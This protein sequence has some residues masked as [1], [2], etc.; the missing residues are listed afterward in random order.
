MLFSQ[1]RWLILETA[2]SEAD[3]NGSQRQS[4]TLPRRQSIRSVGRRANEPA[5]MSTVF[6]LV[7]KS[8]G[9]RLRPRGDGKRVDR[10]SA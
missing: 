5:P 10:D 9:S 3:R 2:R 7:W 8:A 6:G 1:A 4:N